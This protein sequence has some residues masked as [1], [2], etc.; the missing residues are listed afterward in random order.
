MCV[1]VCVCVSVRLRMYVSV[2]VCV[3]R[4]HH[5]H[6]H[7]QI[8]LH[9]RTHTKLQYRSQWYARRGG[10]YCLIGRGRAYANAAAL[11]KTIAAE[12]NNLTRVIALRPWVVGSGGVDR[13]WYV[14]R[15]WWWDGAG[16]CGG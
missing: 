13:E 5:T 11:P 8:H 1:C 14:D 15:E 4:Q 16:G 6:T 12:L 10:A 9:T 2:N 7:T 3:C